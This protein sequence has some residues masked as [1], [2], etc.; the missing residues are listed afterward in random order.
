MTVVN[1][2][3]EP[4]DVYIGRGSVWGNPFTVK[5]MG[6]EAAIEAYREYI[7]KQLDQR[8]ELVTQLLAL[9]GKRLGCFCKPKACHGDVLLDL[10]TITIETAQISVP[11]D[12]G[13]IMADIAH[14]AGLVSGTASGGGQRRI[15]PWNEPLVVNPGDDIRVTLTWTVL[16][17][18]DNNWKVFVHLIDGGNQVIVQQD[19]PPLGGSFPTFLWFPKWVPGQTVLDPYRL[20]VPVDTPLGDYQIEVGMY[21]FTTFQRAHFYDP[22]GNLSGDRFILGTVR[23]EP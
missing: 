11:L 10:G 12:E 18:P 7:T 22:V 14:Q 9:K 3:Y 23:V 16:D 5:E 21:G 13:E 1:K 8:P 6:R 17:A 19:A 4:Y 2:H 15:A 20:T